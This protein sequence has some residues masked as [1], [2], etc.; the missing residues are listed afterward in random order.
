[1]GEYLWPIEHSS[2]RGEK[3]T[4]W[5]ISLASREIREYYKCK[6]RGTLRIS[7]RKPKQWITDLRKEN[8]IKDG[9]IRCIG[10]YRSLR[11]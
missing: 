6:R 5:T 1:M 4:N 2:I 9:L 3:R 7:W 10:V 8:P 11:W